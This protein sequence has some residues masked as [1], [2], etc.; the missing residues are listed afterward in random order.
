MGIAIPR[1]HDQ[2][3]G[4]F[5]FPDEFQDLQT[6]HDRHVDVEENQIEFL[7]AQHL[8]R[9]GTVS[10]RLHLK[11]LEGEMVLDQVPK[12]RLVVSIEEMDCHGNVGFLCVMDSIYGLERQHDVTT[13]IRCRGARRRS[14]I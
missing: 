12:I 7:A 10:R 6:V 3:R 8:H 14:I 1:Q 11:P 5:F 4:Q 2:P 9:L 13:I